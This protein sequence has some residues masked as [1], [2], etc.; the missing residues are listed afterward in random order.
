M[1]APPDM[2]CFPWQ[3]VLGTLP[4]RTNPAPTEPGYSY[5]SRPHTTVQYT[6][7]YGLG[8]THTHA[9]K[10]VQ[11][12]SS[13]KK[14]TLK[15]RGLV[16]PIELHFLSYV[17]PIRILLALT[18]VLYISSIDSYPNRTKRKNRVLQKLLNQINTAPC[19]LDVSIY[20]EPPFRQS[21][22]DA[23]LYC[24]ST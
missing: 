7:R 13:P 22:R 21:S 19:L 14:T 2:L 11:R 10:K 18:L 3:P 23:L 8:Y 20:L 17:L 9:A 24:T 6:V 4:Y 1:A 12:P 5:K 16:L 15:A